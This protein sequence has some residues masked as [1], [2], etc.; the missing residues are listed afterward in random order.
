LT[1]YYQEHRVTHLRLLDTDA[2]GADWQEVAKSCSTSIQNANWI[3]QSVR[4]RAIGPVR[5]G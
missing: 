4:A 3:G 1:R 5:N 2:E